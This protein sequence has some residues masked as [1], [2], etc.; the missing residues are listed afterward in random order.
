MS[1]VHVDVVD[2]LHLLCLLCDLAEKTL[3]TIMIGLQILQVMCASSYI[4]V[5]AYVITEVL[6]NSL[7]PSQEINFK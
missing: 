7:K 5:H 3:K 1:I 4:N 2:H 6:T